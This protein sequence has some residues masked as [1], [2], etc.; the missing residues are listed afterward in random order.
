MSVPRSAHNRRN[1]ERRV[2]EE[3]AKK[4][5]KNTPPP[6]GAARRP[7]ARSAPASKLKG[8][9]PA[10]AVPASVDVS[11]RAQAGGSMRCCQLCDARFAVSSGAVRYFEKRGWPQRTC[12]FDCTT[13]KK[14][15]AAAAARAV[16][17]RLTQ[18]RRPRPRGDDLVPPAVE[19]ETQ[20]TAGAP[21][22]AGDGTRQTA[23]APA[24]AGDGTRQT[25]GAPARAGDGG[26]PTPA[27]VATPGSGAEDDSPCPAED[28]LASVDAVPRVRA[29]SLDPPLNTKELLEDLPYFAASALEDEGQT[30]TGCDVLSIVVWIMCMERGHLVSTFAAECF[31]GNHEPIMVL[32]KLRRCIAKYFTPG[33]GAFL[34]MYRYPPS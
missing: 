25:A 5:K 14:Q 23:G 6:S 13:A 30:D 24:R 16:A 20:Q 27:V 34:P 12:C 2:R 19:G 33:W 22:R 9:R 28:V 31:A 7:G 10:H 3:L 4:R 26:G 32:E 8:A 1:A 29:N 17:E 15:A 18:K 11:T 21:A